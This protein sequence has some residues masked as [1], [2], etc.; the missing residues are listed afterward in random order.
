MEGG[1][2]RGYIEC[3]LDPSYPTLSKAGAWVKLD[4]SRV[5]VGTEAPQV[6]EKSHEYHLQNIS[7]A[8]GMEIM[9]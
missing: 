8:Q 2:Q 9:D 6:T 7:M 1:G 5:L 3:S 4:D